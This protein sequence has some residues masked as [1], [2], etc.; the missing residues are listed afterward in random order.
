MPCISLDLA[1]QSL[2]NKIRVLC[3][4]KLA[5]LDQYLRAPN[6]GPDDEESIPDP[7]IV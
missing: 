2:R 6:F 3:F 7:E 5:W 4:R 1:R